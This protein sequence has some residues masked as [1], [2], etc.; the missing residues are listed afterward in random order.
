ML[1]IIT[2]SSNNVNI[3]SVMLAVVFSGGIYYLGNIKAFPASFIQLISSIAR[4][5]SFSK[6]KVKAIN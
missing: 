6:Y 3:H 1:N 5:R 2:A 4:L